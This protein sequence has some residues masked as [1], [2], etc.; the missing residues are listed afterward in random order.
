M[1][2]RLSDYKKRVP[3]RIWGPLFKIL[4]RAEE[5]GSF[6]PNWRSFEHSRLEQELLQ[7]IKDKV[8]FGIVHIYPRPWVSDAVFQQMSAND[9]FQN[10]LAIPPVQM[11]Y[12]LNQALQLL[13]S[14]TGK[15]VPIA[16]TEYNIGL[17][18][19]SP[20]S[21]RHTLGAALVNADLIRSYMNLG[22]IFLWPTT[23]SLSM[24]IGE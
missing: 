13:K 6:Y 9:V 23:G 2:W 22:K 16:I 4:R 24:S 19:D 11:D 7:I 18:Q 3:R 5:S 17:A 21:Y 15:N 10:T 20:I 8:D 12:Q 1:G 14:Q